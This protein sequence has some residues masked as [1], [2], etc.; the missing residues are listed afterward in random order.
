MGVSHWAFTARR[1]GV[2]D[3]AANGWEIFLWE[4]RI[5]NNCRIL[6]TM[7]NFLLVHQNQG[8]SPGK[9]PVRVQGGKRRRVHRTTLTGVLRAGNSQLGLVFGFA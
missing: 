1:M 3:E 5:D 7:G 8:A 2:G 4:Q 6:L 9:H